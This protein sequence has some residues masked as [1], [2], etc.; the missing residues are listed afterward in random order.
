MTFDVGRRAEILSAEADRYLAVAAANVTREYPSMSPVVAIGPGPIPSH[1]AA[2]PAFYGAFDWHS[3]VEMVWVM[4][5]LLR[6]FPSI[7]GGAGARRVLDTLL[8]PENLATEVA[9]FAAHHHRTIERPY[10]WGWAL[11]L[12]HELETWDDPD[13]RRWATAVRPLADHFAAGLEAWIPRLTYP[14]RTGMHPNTAFGLSLSLDHARWRSERGDGGLARS[15]EEGAQRWFAGDRDYP[16]H[17]EPSG[18]DFL[19]AA[20]AEAE[21]MSRVLPRAEF[22]AWL[23]SFL[24]DL[25]ESRPATLF[26]P[27]T[28]TDVSDGQLAHLL[29]LNLSRA[30]AMTALA[31]RLP[32]G[33]PRVGPLLAG[34]ERQATA[35]LPH[36]VG[37]D[38]MTEHWL[39][40]YA[41]ALL[42]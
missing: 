9:F 13:G 18:A 37:G 15:I 7:A 38:Y 17:Y 39:A 24:P 6:R 35:A 34:A 12:A 42:S 29:G 25:A 10:G 3:C 27:V 1:R 20:L 11:T 26:R 14:Q 22:P 32:T 31:D 41:V 23:A 4:V 36:V 30:W 5:R 21:L 33:D 16:A 40:A 28:V 2:H 19:S 8:T